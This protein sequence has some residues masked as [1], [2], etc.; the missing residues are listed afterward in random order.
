MCGRKSLV[1]AWI[2]WH[3]T[4]R[5]L[6]FLTGARTEGD[7]ASERSHLLRPGHLGVVR[8][9]IFVSRALTTIQMMGA[10]PVQERVE[11]SAVI[12]RP[13]LPL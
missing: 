6:Q 2:P 5:C 12:R 7:P 1:E 10:C 3:G 11:K 13:L 9:A 8:V 4:L